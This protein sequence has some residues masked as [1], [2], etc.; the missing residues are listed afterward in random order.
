MPITGGI[1]SRSPA[2][3]QRGMR[4]PRTG[5]DLSLVTRASVGLAI[6]AAVDLLDRGGSAY[7]VPTGLRTACRHVPC[8][9]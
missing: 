8:S 7:F 1:P 2:A 3:K 5:A 4:P 9:V 6:G